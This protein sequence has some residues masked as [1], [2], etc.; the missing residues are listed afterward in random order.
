MGWG[1][2]NSATEAIVLF[3]FCDVWIEK[4]GAL[5]QQIA[6]NYVFFFFVTF[7]LQCPNNSITN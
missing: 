6:L 3:K 1:C 4:K 5:K 7:Q 2:F